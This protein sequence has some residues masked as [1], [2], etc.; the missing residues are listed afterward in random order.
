MEGVQCQA[1]TK[2][3]LACKLTGSMNPQDNPAYCWRHQ[4]CNT[5]PIINTKTNPLIDLPNDLFKLVMLELPYEDLKSLCRTD[6]RSAKLCGDQNFWREKV[7]RDFN[8]VS[9][10]IPLQLVDNTKIWAAISMNLTAKQ[11]QSY[12]PTWQDFY[13]YVYPLHNMLFTVD[14][15]K[16]FDKLQDIITTHITANTT[17]VNGIYFWD[18][19]PYLSES[20]EPAAELRRAHRDALI[21]HRNVYISVPASSQNVTFTVDQAE[22]AYWLYRLFWYKGYSTGSTGLSPGVFALPF[23]IYHELYDYQA[24]HQA[25]SSLE[26]QMYNLGDDGI[27]GQVYDTLDGYIEVPLDDLI[28]PAGQM[29]ELDR[30]YDLDTSQR[31]TIQVI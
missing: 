29:P 17:V 18:F 9:D 15:L 20:F 3:G 8:I 24:F 21:E 23:P 13:K 4:Q 5:K 12:V 16:Q 1:R 7:G 19:K 26:E 25:E 6:K 11:R 14:E 28:I 31:E 30:Y 22:Q 10:E 27:Y 2:L